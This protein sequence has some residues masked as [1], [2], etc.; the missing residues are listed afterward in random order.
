MIAAPGARCCGSPPWSSPARPSSRSP[1]P[2]A[3]CGWDIELPHEQTVNGF[4][5]VSLRFRY[6]FVRKLMFVRYA[7]AF[8]VF[9][10]GFGT[11]DEFFEALTLIQTGKIRHFPVVL[12]GSRHWDGL[13]T[14]IRAR[15]LD[16]GMVSAQDMALLT[17]AD[18]PNRRG[19]RRRPPPPAADLPVDG[20]L[21]C[22]SRNRREAG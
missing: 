12:A 7:S 5:D 1:S 20:H 6:F 14:W 4:I 18:D 22:R 13:E 16:T 17:V 10:G 21:R 3:H 19:H 8:V 9:P 15:L 11:L 2:P